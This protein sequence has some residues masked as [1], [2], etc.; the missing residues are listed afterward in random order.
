[1]MWLGV[2]TV[3]DDNFPKTEKIYLIMF[4]LTSFRSEFAFLHLLLPTVKF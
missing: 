3:V 1:M 2:K 4:G